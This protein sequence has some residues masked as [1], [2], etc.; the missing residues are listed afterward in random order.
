MVRHGGDLS[1]VASLRLF[2]AEGTLAG[3][4]RADGTTKKF[5]YK[6]VLSCI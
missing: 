6:I 2:V 4:R 3:N 1:Q 5:I